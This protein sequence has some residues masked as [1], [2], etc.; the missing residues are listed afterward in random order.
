[1]TIQWMLSI[2]GVI[3]LRFELEFYIF[4]FK[5]FFN[6]FD[7]LILKINFKKYIILIYFK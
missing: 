2:K 4:Y 6:C 1:M 3:D 7:V 5:L